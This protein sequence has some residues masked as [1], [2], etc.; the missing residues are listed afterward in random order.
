[1]HCE[2]QHCMGQDKRRVT[3]KPQPPAPPPKPPPPHVPPPLA[4][5]PQVSFKD[6]CW[7]RPSN[8]LLCGPHAQYG[9]AVLFWLVAWV[10]TESFQLNC[11]DLPGCPIWPRWLTAQHSRDTRQR[12]GRCGSLSLQKSRPAGGGKR[13]D[14]L[15][16][17]DLDQLNF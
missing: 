13:L 9:S 3:Q 1:M 12:S 6:V 16:L 10:K 8:G 17:S 5:L 4:V 11:P 15:D 14:Q 7:L 2:K